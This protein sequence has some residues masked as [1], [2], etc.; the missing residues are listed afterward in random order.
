MSS[1]TSTEVIGDGKITIMQGTRVAGEFTVNQEDD[2][3]IVL[4]DLVWINWDEVGT[5]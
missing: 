3:T 2:Q 5:L 1:N 4:E